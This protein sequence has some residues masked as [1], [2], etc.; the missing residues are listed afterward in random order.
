M[1]SIPEYPDLERNLYAND[2]YMARHSLRKAELP[3]TDGPIELPYLCG[4]A[5]R[6]YGEICMCI[7]DHGFDPSVTFFERNAL[8]CFISAVCRRA[9]HHVKY[10]HE[11]VIRGVPVTCNALL[12]AAHFKQFQ[13]AEVLL[14]GASRE[15]VEQLID[16]SVTNNAST[17]NVL[18]AYGAVLNTDTLS[19]ILS[20]M[21]LAKTL[22]STCLQVL[23]ELGADES[24]CNAFPDLMENLVQREVASAALDDSAAALDDSAAALDDSTV[25]ISQAD[26]EASYDSGYIVAQPADD[27]GYDVDSTTDSVTRQDSGISGHSIQRFSSYDSDEDVQR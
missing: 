19:R 22:D 20:A 25:D 5:L 10:I 17:T 23:V 16:H 24:I 13:A 14:Q 3:D 27:D 15:V 11:F 18:I 4:A 9:D 21:L 6:G 7:M 26:I 8:E 2:V 12:Y 1:V